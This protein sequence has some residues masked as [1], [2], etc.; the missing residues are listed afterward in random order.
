MASEAGSMTAMLQMK[1]V[2]RI[3]GTR[4]SLPAPRFWPVMELPAVVKELETMPAIM[5]ILL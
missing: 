4:S 3:C 2:L 1:T 5:L